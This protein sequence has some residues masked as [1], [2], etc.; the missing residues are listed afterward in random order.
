MHRKS[1][2]SNENPPDFRWIDKPEALDAPAETEGKVTRL[3]QLVNVLT[4]LVSR[5]RPSGR[6]EVEAAAHEVFAAFA[7]MLKTH[8][9]QARPRA[10]G[11]ADARGRSRA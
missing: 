8:L 10:R 5:T 3:T 9:S 1:M 2:N 4:H 6:H 7:A 11:S